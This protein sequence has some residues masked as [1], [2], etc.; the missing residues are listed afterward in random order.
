MNS[1]AP[2]AIDRILHVAIFR[3]PQNKVRA[4]ETFRKVRRRIVRK[5]FIFAGVVAAFA[6]A[7]PLH[8]QKASL[9]QGS[10][11]GTPPQL[12]T[13][14]IID[15]S[16]LMAPIPNQPPPPSLLSRVVSKIHYPTIGNNPVLSLKTKPPAP[17]PN[18]AS[19]SQGK[20]Q[21]MMPFY[22]Q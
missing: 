15:K 21:P 6:I 20:F 13:E 10:F 5:A 7:G 9:L 17:P 1:I 2:I 4:D 8:A 14:S 18:G 11:S 12:P 22:H 19:A 3:R 16:P